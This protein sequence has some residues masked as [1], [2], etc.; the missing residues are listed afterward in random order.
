MLLSSVFSHI[1]CLGT[2]SQHTPKIAHFRGVK[3]KLAQVEMGWMDNESVNDRNYYF[4]LANASYIYT[5]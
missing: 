4:A 1:T 5:G 3:N 2:A